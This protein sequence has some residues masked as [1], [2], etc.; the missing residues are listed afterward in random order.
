MPQPEE[1]AREK[2]ISEKN[3]SPRDYVETYY[4]SD[5]DVEKLLPIL[6]KV[7]KIDSNI[8]DISKIAEEEGIDPED[9]ENLF[10][11][12]FQ[13]KL[14]EKIIEDHPEKDAKVLD[15]GGGPTIYQHLEIF[16]NIESITHT[17]ILPEN[18]EEV[19]MWV[20]DNPEAHNWDSYFMLTGAN[21]ENIGEMK[22]ELRSKI[23][24]TTCNAL[25][26]NLGL[27]NP[28]RFDAISEV[29]CL[30]AAVGTD[31]AKRR[32]ISLSDTVGNIGN[33]LEEGGYFSMV[34]IR[35]ADWY[36]VGDKKVPVHNTNEDEIENALK[37]NGFEILEQRTLIGSDKEK[38][39][40]DGV[41]L[42]L[43]KKLG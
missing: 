10:I 6:E 24:T 1:T 27:E 37:S 36:K 35:N 9:L 33:S 4:P 43:A 30:D 5:V 3:F 7:S 16:Q 18:L 26:P 39:G 8:V 29:F 40:Y 13:R 20:N 31:E 32:N 25:E 15:V 34:A 41:I 12:D 28:E 2:E 23:K 21:S 42:C 11:L 22:K 38:D 19:D 17:D 14:G